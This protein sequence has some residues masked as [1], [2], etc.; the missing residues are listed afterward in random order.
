MPTFICTIRTRIQMLIHQFPH[1]ALTVCSYFYPIAPVPCMTFFFF[2]LW[3]LNVFAGKYWQR[4][5]LDKWKTSSRQRGRILTTKMYK[6]Q[7]TEMICWWSHRGPCDWLTVSP[8]LPSASWRLTHQLR[9]WR[10]TG[11]C[12][13]HHHTAPHIFTLQPHLQVNRS[14]HFTQGDTSH[15]YEPFKLHVARWRWS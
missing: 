4:L 12:I 3:I 6:S 8:T 9:R 5:R 7:D 13:T 11:A 10:R 15:L 1:T 14:Q 2:F